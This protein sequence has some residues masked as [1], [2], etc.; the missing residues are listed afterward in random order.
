MAIKS[1]TST[2]APRGTKTL[3]QAF[4]SAADSVPE[5]QRDAVVKAAL[6]AIRDELK[7]D[8]AKAKMAR[9]KARSKPVRTTAAKPTASK[10]AAKAA[11]KATTKSPAK[12]AAAPKMKR[13]RSKPIMEADEKVDMV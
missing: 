3:T 11:A 12:A 13:A 7:A 10:P 8:K 2:R 1:T 5:A 9:A 4:F 6:A